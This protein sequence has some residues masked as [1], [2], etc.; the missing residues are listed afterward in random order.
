LKGDLESVI[1][2]NPLV[3]DYN[4]TPLQKGARQGESGGTNTPNSLVLAGFSVNSK[5]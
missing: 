4:T 1:I 5:Y 2:G 3:T